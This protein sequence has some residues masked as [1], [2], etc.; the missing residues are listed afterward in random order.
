MMKMRMR[1]RK[2]MMMKGKAKV[3]VKAK[4]TMRMTMISNIRMWKLTNRRMMMKLM[5]IS[6]ISN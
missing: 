2:K 1:M 4:I 3:K 6:M 5:M